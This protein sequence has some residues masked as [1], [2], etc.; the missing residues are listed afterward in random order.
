MPAELVV[1]NIPKVVL[2][3]EDEPDMVE[4]VSGYLIESGFKVVSAKKLSE[5]TAK[6]NNQKYHCMIIDLNLE[7]GSGKQLMQYVR[8]DKKGQ[9]YYTPIIVMS[10]FVDLP[11]VAELKGMVQE[12]IAKPAGKEVIVAKIKS[13][14]EKMNAEK[15]GAAAKAAKSGKVA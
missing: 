2:L 6:A 5:A 3:V 14:H 11:T 12:F 10:A 13:A 15:K 1:S 8:S 4:L 7:Q 9:N